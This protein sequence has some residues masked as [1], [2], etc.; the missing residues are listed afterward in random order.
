MYYIRYQQLRL[1][2]LHREFYEKVVFFKS[3]L[4]ANQTTVELMV[5]A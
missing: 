2:D 1:K 4:L 5:K 3:R